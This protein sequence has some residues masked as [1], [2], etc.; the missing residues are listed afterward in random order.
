MKARLLRL[1]LNCYPPLLGAGIHVQR[2]SADFSE[3]DV[4]MPL[5]WYN[6]NY[7]GTQFGGSLYAMTDPVLML[8]AMQ[9]LGR[10][11]LVWDQAAAID[12]VAPGRG[13]VFARFRL[14]DAEI[15]RLR[16]DAAHGAA[17]RP[18][19]EIRITDA[20]DKLVARVKKTLYVRL[21]KQRR[22]A[23]SEAWPQ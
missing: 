23:G 5:R 19:Y 11:Y 13:R 3:I 16:E 7:V 9:R 21:K 20:D 8:M 14:P 18:Q 4:S 22:P 6:R 2:I 12:F 10:D 17:I 1:A 15:A